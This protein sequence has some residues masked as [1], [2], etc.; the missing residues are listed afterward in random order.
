[1]K[2]IQYIEVHHKKPLFSLDSEIVSNPS[3]DMI[4]VCSNCHR[5]LHRHK[6]SIISP[7]ELIK[8][9]NTQKERDN[10]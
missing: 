3:T 1:M 7:E 9:L 8:I 4:C 2:E 5:M 6:D 10:T